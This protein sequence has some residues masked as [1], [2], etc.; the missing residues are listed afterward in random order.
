MSNI[1]KIHLFII[2]FLVTILIGGCTGAKIDHQS[3]KAGDYILDQDAIKTVTFSKAIY[4]A[5]EIPVDQEDGSPDRSGEPI[6][7]LQGMEKEKRNA[8]LRTIKSSEGIT[9][10]QIARVTGM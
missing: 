5:E 10:R 8:I 9:L 4:E 2:S 7:K 1:P 3:T 6:A